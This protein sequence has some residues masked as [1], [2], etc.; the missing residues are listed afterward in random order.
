MA[1]LLAH[2][3][4]RARLFAHD[5]EAAHRLLF[6]LERA[7]FDLFDLETASQA[8][9]RGLA[10]HDLPGER[11]RA[12]SRARVRRIADDGVRER[13]GASHIPDDSGAGVDADADRQRR[14][15]LADALAAELPQHP[16]LGPR[17]LNAPHPA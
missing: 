3:G 5:V 13:L 6:S 17:A 1:T 16:P 8:R 11:A 9:Q 12:K 10:D 2:F 4:H 14:L 15:A 7:G